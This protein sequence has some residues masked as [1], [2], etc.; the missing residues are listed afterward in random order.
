MTILVTGTTG[1]IGRLVVDHLLE[2]TG[3]PIRALTVD[4]ARAALPDGV[5]AV[6][7]SVYRPTGWTES[8][9]VSARCTSRRWRRPPPR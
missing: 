6:R 2:R 8:S 4:P 5:E 3:E 1:N 9:T 7:G